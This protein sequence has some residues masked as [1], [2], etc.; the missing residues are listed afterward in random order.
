VAG[1]GSCEGQTRLDPVRPGWWL[2]KNYKHVIS[3]HSN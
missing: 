2:H 3:G 1:R